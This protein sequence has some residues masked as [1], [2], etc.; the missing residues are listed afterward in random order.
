MQSTA[1]PVVENIRP[2]H[3]I[4]GQFTVTTT[5]R[6]EGEP[7]HRVGFFTNVY[8]GPV[9]LV[10]DRNISIRVVDPERF[11]DLVSDPVAWVRAFY[12]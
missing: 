2:S 1:S 8:G 12:A 4:A 10:T 9:H 3:G 11:G 6:R 5:V 7:V